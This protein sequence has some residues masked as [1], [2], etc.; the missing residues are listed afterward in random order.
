MFWIPFGI[1]LG[2]FV[3]VFALQEKYIQKW[4]KLEGVTEEDAEAVINTNLIGWVHV[5]VRH[6]LKKLIWKFL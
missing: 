5:K 4:S 1:V 3:G 2:S 6:G